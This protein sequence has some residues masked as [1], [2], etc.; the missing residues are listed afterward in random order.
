MS[1]AEPIDISSSSDDAV[2]HDAETRRPD[3]LYII[4]RASQPDPRAPFGNETPNDDIL[5][6]SMY[7]ANV[8]A[9]RAIK[10]AE[11]LYS[12]DDQADDDSHFNHEASQDEDAEEHREPSMKRKRL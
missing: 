12:G 3:T 11:D 10:N 1:T 7:E 2:S 6:E 4:L 5:Y 9:R 8:V